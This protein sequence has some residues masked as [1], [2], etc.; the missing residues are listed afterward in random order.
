MVTTREELLFQAIHKCFVG[1]NSI[2]SNLVGLLSPNL[3]SDF[4]TCEEASEYLSHTGKENWI[5]IY[6]Q[7]C[8]WHEIMEARTMLEKANML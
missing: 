2:A 8:C 6:E 5:E 1:G 3:P 7:W 4:H